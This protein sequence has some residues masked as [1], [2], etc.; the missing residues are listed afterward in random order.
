MRELLLRENDSIEKL[1]AFM[2]ECSFT[3]FTGIT[4]EKTLRTRCKDVK[5]TR[6]HR[7]GDSKVYKT[8]PLAFDDILGKFH[9]GKL[10]IY[11]GDAPNTYIVFRFVRY[12][13]MS[14]FTFCKIY[15][16]EG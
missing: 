8:M 9:I 12:K 11:R 16:L 13:T 6:V 14:V 15:S 3:G 7:L 1:E 5:H 10:R 4:Y 2:D